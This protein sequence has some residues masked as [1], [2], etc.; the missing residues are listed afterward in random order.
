MNK[1]FSLALPAL[2]A[3]SLL[4]SSRPAVAAPQTLSAQEVLDAAAQKYAGFT[5]YQGTCSILIDGAASIE[6][7][8]AQHSVS[9]A[10]STVAFERDKSLKVTGTNSFGGTFEALSTPTS[11]TI[12]A[13]G[14]GDKKM[15]LFQ[16]TTLNK[17]EMSEFLGGLTGIS[18][19][20]GATLPALLLSDS[21]INPL[22]A[23]GVAALLPMRNLG[24]T[25]CYIVTKTNEEYKAVRTFWIE[26]DSFLLRR[27]DIEMGETKSPK[28]T[29]EVLA[30]YPQ[31]KDMPAITTQYTNHIL[32]FATQS[33]E[34]KPWYS[35]R[36]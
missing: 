28:L 34:T 12:T 11:T 25:P 4:M 30:K 32:I 7:E 35:P 23:K 19:G 10:N 13:S 1:L 15:T 27:L 21:E 29:A 24:A 31:L 22:R 16:K 18:G 3:L 9:S 5:Q 17:E 26:K 8:P 6:G 33:A 2:L 36:N 14:A 20:G